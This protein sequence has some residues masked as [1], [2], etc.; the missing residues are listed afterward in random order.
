MRYLVYFRDPPDGWVNLGAVCLGPGEAP[1]P[2]TDITDAVS[3]VFVNLPPENKPAFYPSDA[4]LVNLPTIFAAG[5]PKAMA[6]DNLDVLGFDIRVTAKASYDWTFDRG[7]TKTFT[8]PGGAY[9]DM[10]VTHTYASPGER[11]VSLT[12]RWRG[13]FYI[14]GDGPYD[15][16]GTVDKESGPFDV[17]VHEA[18][19]GLVAERG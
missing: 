2:I 11:G 3:D 6:W 16:P 7:V 10:S 1:V 9:P 14:G 18:T 8:E 5:A 17:P 13:Q 15:I 19:S 12:T 4:A